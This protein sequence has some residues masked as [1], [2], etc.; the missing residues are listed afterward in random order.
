MD[1]GNSSG[2]SARDSHPSCIFGSDIESDPKFSGQAWE[3]GTGNGA[4]RSP[5][6]GSAERAILGA[7]EGGRHGFVEGAIG[8][9]PFES[10]LR[11][12]P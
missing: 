4:W 1:Q 3:M 6:V 9:S 12:M 7:S 11:G 2:E 10:E 8:D 5:T